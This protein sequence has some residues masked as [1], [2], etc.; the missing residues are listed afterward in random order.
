MRS[1]HNRSL[2]RSAGQ[3]GITLKSRAARI[4]TV[5]W[6]TLEFKGR[7]RLAYGDVKTVHTAQGSTTREHWDASR[8][9]PGCGK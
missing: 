6:T 5:A 7:S 1:Q 4:G 3:R 8:S 2:R 9:A